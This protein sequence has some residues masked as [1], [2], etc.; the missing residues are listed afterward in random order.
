MGASL[1]LHCIGTTVALGEADLIISEGSI[2]ISHKKVEK[3]IPLASVKEVILEEPRMLMKGTLTIST[4]KGVTG[5]IPVAGILAGVGQEE[6]FVFTKDELDNARA[7]KQFIV[8][9]LKGTTA[10]HNQPSVAD[11]IAKYKNLLDNG[12]ITEDEY[13]AL[14]SRLIG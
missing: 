14:K 11:E 7:V 2:L 13:A 5:F 4:G 6:K 3:T 9:F 12:A 10:T 1:R 8:D